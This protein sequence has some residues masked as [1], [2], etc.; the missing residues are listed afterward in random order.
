MRGLTRLAR[1]VTP[2]LVAGSLTVPAVTGGT[3]QAATTALYVA[4]G[5]VSCNNSGPGTQAIPFCSIQAAADVVNPGQTVNIETSAKNYTQPVT[6]TRSGT[7]QAPITFTRFGPGLIPDIG[8]SALTG[9]SV[10]FNNVQ[11]VN[12]TSLAVTHGNATGIEVVG[13]QHLTFDQLQVGQ[14]GTAAGAATGI[15]ADGASSAVMV[16]R[17][18]IFGTLGYGVR[19]CRRAGRHRDH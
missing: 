8:S 13:S 2:F 9:P 1:A 10:T 3:A 15:D 5:S 18:Y 4:Q 6:I 14:E 7:E 19:V 17:T 16:S 12:F 11:Y